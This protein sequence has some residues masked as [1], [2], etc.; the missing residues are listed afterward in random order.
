MSDY[1]AFAVE[2]KNKAL[3]EA[4]KKGLMKTAQE[5]TKKSIKEII[6]IIP[7]TDE[8]TIEVTFKE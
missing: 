8:Y 2:Q 1:K 7:D 3:A 4:K 5:N 6:S